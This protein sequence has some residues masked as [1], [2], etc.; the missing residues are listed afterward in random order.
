MTGDDSPPGDGAQ[1]SG[2]RSALTWLRG[3]PWVVG[4]AAAVAL[5]LVA[6]LVY[7][8]QSRTSNGQPSPGD[9][10][11]SGRRTPQALVVSNWWS[12]ENGKPILAGATSDRPNLDD[13]R[14]VETLKRLASRYDVFII[15]QPS[16]HTVG[17]QVRDR[18]KRYAAEQGRSIIALRYFGTMAV[19]PVADQAGDMQAVPARGRI[20]TDGTV[21]NADTLLSSGGKPVKGAD[22][23]GGYLVDPAS[24]AARK[25]AADNVSGKLA[26][27]DGA[28]LDEVG[29]GPNRS[30]Q[31]ARSATSRYSDD[32]AG[33][34][35]FQAATLGYVD[36]VK[37]A[38]G[39]KILA[40]NITPSTTDQ[41]FLPARVAEHGVTYPFVEVFGAGWDHD[42]VTTR[43]GDLSTLRATM[44]WLHDTAGEPGLHP[45][46]NSLTNDG[47]TLRYSYALFLASAGTNAV[48]AGHTGSTDVEYDQVPTWLPEYE[49]PVGTPQGDAET[50]GDRLTRTWSGAQVEADLRAGTGKI[51][52]RG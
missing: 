51:T 45:I 23:V 25:A 52:R 31:A 2:A 37:A 15:V 17:Q 12:A 28:Y 19:H 38:V 35:A 39:D 34:A 7:V 20:R 50:D 3:R 4:L 10:G 16:W 36:A 29:W 1:A 43:S 5:C 14:N 40:A 9:A 21:T 49:Y 18:L 42:P 46:V 47:A 24:A 33:R 13:S 44:S 32:D 30:L 11:G 8:V 27:W 22:S 48:Y 41:G 6:T 26:G